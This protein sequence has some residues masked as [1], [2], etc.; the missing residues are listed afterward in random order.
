[1]F[2][3]EWGST[4]PETC[5]SGEETLM[6]WWFSERGR[7]TKIHVVA[8]PY[9][10]QKIKEIRQGNLA[11]QTL[12]GVHIQGV[13][14]DLWVVSRRQLVFS[15][16]WPGFC[17]ACQYHERLLWQTRA[18]PDFVTKFQVGPMMPS[19]MSMMKGVMT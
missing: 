6:A 13:A 1:M 5:G 19:V 15:R 10:S 17:K 7:K 2:T 11:M 3:P 4:F 14:P 18:L 8:Y 9:P 16:D 12:C